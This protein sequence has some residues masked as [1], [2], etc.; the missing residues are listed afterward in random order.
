MFPLDFSVIFYTSTGKWKAPVNVGHNERTEPVKEHGKRKYYGRFTIGGKQKWVNLETDV[1]TIAKVRV[2]EE[3][4]KIERLRQAADSVTAGD[5]HMGA[6]AAL[7]RQ[8]IEDR[9]D[10]KPK[11]KRRLR[12]EV[13][14]IIKTWPRLEH[15]SPSQITRQA[16]L[17]WRNRVNREGTGFVVP[18][19]KRSSPKI[20]GSSASL[21]NKCID[22]LRRML[23]IAVERGQIAGNLL[24]PRGLKLK[25]TPRKPE[26]PEPEKLAEVFTEI[27]RAG[28]GF[29][30][31]AADFCRFLAYT[32]CR[33][34]EAQGV[35]WGD[36]DF[37][38]GILRVRGSK[39]EAADREVPLIPAARAL[40]ERLQAAQLT[41]G[42]TEGES[43]A[44]LSAKSR[45]LRVREAAKSLAAACRKV[46][47]EPLTHHDLRDAFATA[48]IEAGVDIPTVAAWLGHADGGALLMRVYAHH[49]RA[50]SIAQAAKVLAGT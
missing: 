2:A 6:L 15:L 41:D 44:T 7:Y 20:N 29:S 49:R 33:L 34:S 14:T 38:R 31:S 45:V 11:T 26:L 19:A 47:I 12:E 25:N 23:D 13:E 36:V 46:G 22:A 16:V 50:H 32:G 18:G 21:I 40:L 8:R 37:K 9:V 35:T 17:E 27:E 48:A 24:Y 5:A 4:A 42:K 10:I 3:R 43:P 1:W 28:G 39:T 30:R